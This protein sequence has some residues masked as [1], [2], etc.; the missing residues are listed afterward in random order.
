MGF[1][2]QIAG[3]SK[4]LMSCKLFLDSERIEIRLDVQHKVCSLDLI[5]RYVSV[6]LTKKRGDKFFLFSAQT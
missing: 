3:K 2:H 1:H 4:M 5:A 6:F